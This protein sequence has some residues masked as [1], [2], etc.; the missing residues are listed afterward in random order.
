M[1]DGYVNIA[2]DDYNCMS[3]KGVE[4]PN[5]LH[6]SFPGDTFPYSYN[7]FTRRQQSFKQDFEFVD[8]SR[9]LPDIVFNTL[10]TNVLFKNMAG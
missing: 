9:H 4:C 8:R 2:F 3:T 5:R 6:V 10:Y 7:I 1:F